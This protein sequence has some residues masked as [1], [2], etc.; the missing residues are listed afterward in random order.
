MSQNQGKHFL[1]EV[2]G[3]ST[4]H[5]KGWFALAYEGGWVGTFECNCCIIDE[6]ITFSVGVLNKVGEGHVTVS[7]SDGKR[8]I[9]HGA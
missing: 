9:R 6:H 1:G 7:I 4:I 8:V 3:A 5:I 2:K